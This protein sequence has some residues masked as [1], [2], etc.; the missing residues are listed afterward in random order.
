[1]PDEREAIPDARTTRGSV[2]RRLRGALRREWVPP[3]LLTL[4]L[5]LAGI[6][7][8]EVWRDELATWSA[9]TRSPD[10]LLGLLGNLDASLGV[11]YGFLHAW[12]SL[13][14]DSAVAMRIPSA[15]AM[16][17]AAVFVV[18]VTRRLYTPRIALVAGLLFAVT[19]GISRYAQEARPPAFAVLAV[20]AS[21][22]VLLVAIERSR[23]RWWVAYAATVACV[24][25]VQ[26]I[27]LPYLAGHAVAVGLW[28]GRRRDLAGFALAACVG[29]AVA[30]PLVFAGLGQSGRQLRW[31]RP[32]LFEFRVFPEQIFSSGTVAGAVLL[33]AVLALVV[34]RRDAAAVLFTLALVPPFAIF[35]A[36]QGSVSYWSPRYL[37]FTVPAWVVLGAAGLVVATTHRS[38]VVAGALAVT[39]LALHAHREVRAVGAHDQ[40]LYPYPSGTG[41]PV[42]Y[43][44]A[45]DLIAQRQQPGDGVAYG[46]RRDWWMVALGLDYHLSRRPTRP[47]DVFQARTATESDDLWATECAVPSACLRGERRIWLV[48]QGRLDDPY[49]RLEP[50]KR[51]TLQSRYETDA[52][53]HVSGLTVA[54]LT[55]RN[56]PPS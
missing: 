23:A 37:L 30:L 41:D 35:L 8:P 9:V 22:Y 40:W 56:R 39:A 33:L 50:D 15:L 19:P 48:S 45:A 36:S 27:A 46:N 16:A 28:H 53:H 10:D 11:Y 21:T 51:A 12:V 49:A 5:G 34:T 13:F 25:L 43:S 20:M 3:A 17:A 52:V 38:T 14:G 54:L 32:S 31:V 26:V 47:R 4:A 1:M 29:V 2:A 24:G 42:L 7:G 18:L 44:Q 6:G 55:A